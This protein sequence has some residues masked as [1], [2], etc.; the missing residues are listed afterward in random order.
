MNLMT[1]FI[2]FILAMIGCIMSGHTMV[3]ALFIG[4]IV[5]TATG[6]KNG[7]TIGE[8]TKMGRDGLK[9]ALVVVDRKSVV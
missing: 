2:I 5:F 8:L 6:Y 3:I 4:L 1:S 7:F 9:D